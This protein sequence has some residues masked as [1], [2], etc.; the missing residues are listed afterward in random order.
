MIAATAGAVL[1]AVAV[2]VA[3]ALSGG[4]DGEG[5]AATSPGD[6]ASLSP[7]GGANDLFLQPPDP[8]GQNPFTDSTSTKAAA[9]PP[10]PS[11]PAGATRLATVTGSDPGL[12]GGTRNVASCDVERQIDFLA[13]DEAKGAAF[14]AVLGI[15]AEEVPAYLRGLTPV[16]LRLD[17]RVTNHGYRDGKPYPYQAVL[18][19]GTA[20]LVDARGE[21]RV[22]CAC[23]NPLTSPAE[24][25]SGYDMQG[26]PWRGFDQSQVVVVR[27]AAKPVES[28]VLVT[29]DGGRIERHRGDTDAN[30]DERTTK[31]PGT[32]SPSPGGSVT[33][34]S[35]RDPG[36][37]TVPPGEPT[38]EGRTPCPPESPQQ[39]PTTTT[40][41]PPG[42]ETP[43]GGTTT[44]EPPPGTGSAPGD[45]ATP[46]GASPAPPDGRRSP[47]CRRPPYARPPSRP[48]RRRAAGPASG[49][50][51]ERP[52]LR[53][54]G[55]GR[56]HR[57]RP[58]PEA[59][60]AGPGGRIRQ[61]LGAAGARAA[62]GG[63]GGPG[64]PAVQSFAAT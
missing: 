55:S 41:P 39:P 26:E 38:P 44:E 62:G 1:V 10:T 46:G 57:E 35:P 48:R 27:P 59:A 40:A 54:A 36:C 8:P 63:G 37:V 58:T 23:G 34:A 43:G 3:L 51:C 6:L 24:L 11:R 31:S 19:A 64:A 12:Y 47:P 32:Q 56:A 5:S 15:T 20:V 22:R 30:D 2:A 18:Q 9:T 21:P 7:A 16:R 45:E 52:V 25:R 28:F 13:A 53:T 4:G 61:P 29:P 14:A 60:A 49:R 17:T 50:S 33:T 42:E